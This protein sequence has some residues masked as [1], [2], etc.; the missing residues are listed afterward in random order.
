MTTLCQK[1][2]QDY[3]ARQSIII[4]AP[5]G[6][7]W[8]A[9]INPEIIKL[10]LFGTQ[11]TSDWKVGSSITYRG[12]WKSKTYEDKGKILE[13]VP[14]RLF[15]STY[16]SSMSGLPDIPENYKKVTWELLPEK[17]GIRLVVTQDNN[18]TEA[19]KNHSE[20]NWKMVLDKM[21]EILEG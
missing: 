17:N 1:M 14:E 2:K 8:D 4:D 6:R 21:K 3:I 5:A 13:L 9:L 20:G 19:E 18:A 10:Y 11:V 7:V 16:W 12:E 15:I